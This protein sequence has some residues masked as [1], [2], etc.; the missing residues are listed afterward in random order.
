MA[1][2][3]ANLK[4]I[5][6]AL[7]EVRK[8]VIGKDEEV[9]KVMIAFLAGGHVLV[10]DIPG[11][12]KTT[13]A[14]AFA[15][16]LGLKCNRMQFTPDVMPSDIVGFNMYNK[17]TGEFQYKAGAVNCNIFLADEINRT[18]PKTQSALLQ[19]MEEGRTS[20]D[21]KIYRLPEPFMVIA[22]QNPYG[23]IGT[24]SL[25]ESQLDRFMIKISMGYPKV[26]EEVSILK[27]KQNKKAILTETVIGEEELHTIKENVDDVFVDD[28]IYEYIAM[29]AKAT[30]EHPDVS[31]GLSPRGSIAL[32]RISKAQ[33][34]LRGRDYV[35]PSDVQYIFKDVVNHR[36][37]LK[38]SMHRGVVSADSVSS[39]VIRS[40]S[41]PTVDMG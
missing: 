4:K 38:N 5:K 32:L 30:R 31:Q 2:Y 37:V 41:I 22:T 36:I 8:S 6:S 33:A 9:C 16:A 15:K 10:E 40:V 28:S 17:A 1:D 7:I 27:A 26:E 12:G 13:M 3:S 29:L 21:G 19:V 25:P 20:V 24:Q 18:S 11:V 35:L 39:S 34:F 23:S 14:T